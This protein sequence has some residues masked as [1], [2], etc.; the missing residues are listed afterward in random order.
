[1]KVIG[2]ISSLIK[3]D[4]CDPVSYEK[5]VRPLLMHAPESSLPRRSAMHVA[6]DA[7]DL[8]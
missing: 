6:R 2:L 4:N 8:S 3:T 5:Q 7:G 1:M